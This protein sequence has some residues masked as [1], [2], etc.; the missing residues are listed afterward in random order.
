MH[1]TKYMERLS[2]E[3][4]NYLNHGSFHPGLRTIVKQYK[5][6]VGANLLQQEFVRMLLH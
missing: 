4:Y 3:W 6:T 2:L 5:V 1:A